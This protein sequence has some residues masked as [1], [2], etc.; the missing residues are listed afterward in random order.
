MKISVISGV[1]VGLVAAVL[2]G[3]YLIAGVRSGA[4]NT[5][6]QVS[7]EQFLIVRD[8]SVTDAEYLKA[9]QAMVG[10]LR[11]AGFAVSDPERAPQGRYGYRY[12]EG[13][14]SLDVVHQ[15]EAIVQGCYHQNLGEVDRVWQLSPDH[16]QSAEELGFSIQRCVESRKSGFRFS[17]DNGALIRQVVAFQNEADADFEACWSEVVHSLFASTGQTAGSVDIAYRPLPR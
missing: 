2:L 10:C 3:A 14:A 1:A 7:P 9:S 8:G 5:G 15:R 6:R 13:A 4:A 11:D 17:G 16:K 12:L